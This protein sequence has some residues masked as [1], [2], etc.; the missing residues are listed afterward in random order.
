MTIGTEE[1]ARYAVSSR[2]DPID[3]RSPD[4]MSVA[5]VRHGSSSCSNV[6]LPLR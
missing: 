3:T 5:T 4:W 2:P 6:S 1:L